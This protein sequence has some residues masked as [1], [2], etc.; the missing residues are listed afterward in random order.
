MQICFG[1]PDEHFMRLQRC[2]DI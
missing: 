2:S 1:F